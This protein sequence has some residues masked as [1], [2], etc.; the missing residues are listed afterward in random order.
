[1]SSPAAT[2]PPPAPAPAQKDQEMKTI[3]T[4]KPDEEKDKDK[5][6]PAAVA[7]PAPAPAPTPA[8]APAPPPKPEPP[9]ILDSDS[10]LLKYWDAWVLILNI[11]I[12]IVLPVRIG[13]FLTSV[14]EWLAFDLVADVCHIVDML[15]RIRRTF[16]IHGEVIR[17]PEKI[18]ELYLGSTEFILDVVSI[19]PVDLGSIALPK[20]RPCFLANRFFRSHCVWDALAEWEMVTK[21]KP[22]LI[23]MTK[24]LIYLYYV[25]HIDACVKHL[26]LYLEDN[27]AEIRWM[28]ASD[29][30]RRGF[31]DRYFRAYY[32][33]LVGASGF[34]SPTPTTPVE[35]VVSIFDCVFSIA[36]FGVIIGL[37][38]NI[39]ANLDAARIF[40][41]HQL[42]EANEYMRTQ[43]LSKE[44]VDSVNNYYSYLWS[45]GQALEKNE[46]LQ[47]LPGSIR[48]NIAF[49]VT[50]S[51]IKKVPFF[52]DVTK[53][54]FFIE[55]CKN[56]LPRTALPATYIVKKGEMGTEMFFVLRGEL[57]VVLDNGVVVF[58]FAP[59]G[60][61]G[62]IAIMYQ[63]K[64]TATIIARTYCDMFVLGKADFSK[65]LKKFPVESKTIKNIAKERFEAINAGEKEKAEAERKRREED[66]KAATQR[67]EMT[68]ALNAALENEQ[69]VESE[70]E[71]EEEEEE[72]GE[73]EYGKNNDDNNNLRKISS[74]GST[75]STS[76]RR[77]K[78]NSD[79]M[80]MMIQNSAANLLQNMRSDSSNPSDENDSA[81]QELK[82]GIMKRMK[83]KGFRAQNADQDGGR[84]S[85]ADLRNSL[86]QKKRNSMKPSDQEALLPGQ[87][88]ATPGE[89][90]DE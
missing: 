14:N 45:S 83:E 69:V 37:F 12:I 52:K 46:V 24:S 15:I 84:N 76:S 42:D 54:E 88:T 90:E 72:E 30:L 32:L 87:A 7:T 66:L 19:V 57:N 51:F 77:K 53:E 80:K 68:A 2:T 74:I 82:E 43:R 29:Y 6:T 4:T 67:A 89:D 34:N 36:V 61:F 39:L 10:E 21:M 56:L 79:P 8:P 31:W 60:F 11:F 50:S 5:A 20:Y 22:S 44:L 18:R 16:T 71:D 23:S 63:T 27:D 64:R 75:S 65:V 59:G 73:E 48:H 17:D 9:L 35:C 40:F 86:N 85:E 25:V 26:I 78:N 62:E 47:Q 13:F 41:F 28:S 1:M 55:I 3:S 33:S 81:R 58:T 70:G 38:A 49:H